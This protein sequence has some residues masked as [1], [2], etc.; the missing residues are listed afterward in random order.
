MLC[1]F[2]RGR[3]TPF[4][5]RGKRCSPPP[6][7]PPPLP[8]TRFSG[9]CT[10]RERSRLPLY[11]RPPAAPGMLCRFA[12]GCCVGFRGGREPLF[13]CAGKGVPL[14]L[15]LPHPSPKRA[16][17]EDVPFGKACVFPCMPVPRRYRGCCVAFPPL[18]VHSGDGCGR[19][20]GGVPGMFHPPDRSALGKGWGA[21][22]EGK[23]LSR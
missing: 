16:F 3:G 5:W 19:E 7:A 20:S 4:R 2:S 17:Q 10:V 18:L 1:R 21:W 15:A 14:P 22:G 23:P 9:G 11:A 12:R 13:A 6:R 8:K